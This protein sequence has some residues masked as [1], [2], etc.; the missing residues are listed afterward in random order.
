MADK[1]S[2]FGLGLLIGTVVG[3]LTAFFFS[4]KSGPENREE[5]SE[6]AKKIYKRAKELLE[7]K[8][9]ELKKTVDHI[10]K[11]KYMALVEEVMKKLG[12]EA[13]KDV[14]QLEKLKKQLM[15]EWDK[16]QH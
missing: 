9:I 14:K 2:K 6:E 13:K 1:K 15:K 12:K 5:V 7:P 3:G 8:L 11:E 10:D 16:L 4:H